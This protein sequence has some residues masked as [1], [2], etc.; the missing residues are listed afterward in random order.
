MDSLVV[1]TNFSTAADKALEYATALARQLGAK[2]H[3]VHF[4]EHSILDANYFVEVPVTSAYFNHVP[5]YS[6]KEHEEALPERCARFGQEVVIEPHFITGSMLDKLPGILL[7]IPDSFVV[8]GKGYTKDIPDE[9]VDS[10]SLQLLSLKNTP[11]LMVPENYELVVP[12]KYEHFTLPGKIAL[13]LDGK[14]INPPGEVLKDLIHA[15]R[16]DL[17]IIHINTRPGETV[18][19][20]LAQLS[21]KF[22]GLVTP[23]IEV[24]RASADSVSSRIKKYCQKNK[25]DLLVLLHRQHSFLH[26][27]FHES[28]TGALI[29][30][31]AIPLLILPG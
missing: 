14:E 22:L 11:V 30:H 25:I 3:L 4:W 10:T 17:C 20:K 29:Q 23:K 12:E 27:L 15:L 26:G 8:I 6:R 31:T 28:T 13:A 16:V 19:D 9:M 1:L 2:I 5:V 21:E 7:Q 24:E 18:P